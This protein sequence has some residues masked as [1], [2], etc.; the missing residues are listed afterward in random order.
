MGQENYILDNFIRAEVKAG[1]FQFNEAH[2]QKMSALLDEE[3]TKPKPWLQWRWVLSGLAILLAVGTG[4]Y[5]VSRGA[6][7]ALVST[8]QAK[9]AAIDSYMAAKRAV[10]NSIAG[11]SNAEANDE[12]PAQDNTYNSNATTTTTPSDNASPASNANVETSKAPI[13]IV[14]SVP[15][16]AMQAALIPTRSR[17][18]A[19]NAQSMAAAQNMSSDPQA[20][21]APSSRAVQPSDNSISVSN[22]SAPTTN[23]TKL[24]DSKGV[25]PTKQAPANE[26]DNNSKGNNRKATTTQDQSTGNN[27]PHIGAVDDNIATSAINIKPLPQSRTSLKSTANPSAKSV[28]L[29]MSKDDLFASV[30]AAQKQYYGGVEPGFVMWG[31]AGVSA[32]QGWAGTDSNGKAFGVA[33]YITIGGEKQLSDKLTIGGNVGYSLSNALNTSKSVLLNEYSFGRDTSRFSASFQRYTYAFTDIYARYML[34]NAFGIQAGGGAA[35]MLDTRAQLY[36]KYN[37]SRYG[38]GYGVG[39]GRTDLYASLGLHMNLHQRVAL[40]VQYQ[41]GFI[42]L[43]NNQYFGNT[44]KDQQRRVMVGLRYRLSRN[45]YW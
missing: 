37:G 13:V 17:K 15:S 1:E 45:K 14:N 40:Q 43:T 33:P 35:Y 31:A 24:N 30:Q 4:A 39:F 22:A 34:S 3:D 23:D 5:W 20:K 12:T 9:S 7:K 21:A 2:W 26:N 10:Q 29:S 27:A 28:P 19:G 25:N 8:T 44:N 42:D 38:N 41:H 11:T 36:D 16:A 6:N 32:H 18:G